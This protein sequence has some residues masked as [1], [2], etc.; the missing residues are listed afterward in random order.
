MFFGNINHLGNNTNHIFFCRIVPE[1]K[2]YSIRFKNQNEN[3]N[4]SLF[5]LSKSCNFHIFEYIPKHFTI[6]TRISSYKFN[7]EFL[8]DTSSLISDLLDKNPNENQ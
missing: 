6:S 4:Q 8:K 7:T 2:Y 3:N 1:Y 5:L